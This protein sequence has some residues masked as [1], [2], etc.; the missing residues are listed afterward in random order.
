M[1][2]GDV[3]KAEAKIVRV[4]RSRGKEAAPGMG[5]EF[6]DLTPQDRKVLTAGLRKLAD[7][8]T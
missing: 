1:P 7:G 4:S 3:V 8:K 2:D 6:S 5:I